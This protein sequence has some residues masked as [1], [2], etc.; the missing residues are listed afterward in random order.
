MG[1]ELI[2]DDKAVPEGVGWDNTFSETADVDK[3]QYEEDETW[4]KQWDPND[5]GKAGPIRM[6][7]FWLCAIPGLLLP[8]C[9]SLF[10]PAI[11]NVFAEF[12]VESAFIQTLTLSIYSLFS[13][14]FPLVWGPISDRYSRKWVLVVN[15][16]IYAVVSYLNSWNFTIWG[17]IVM[18]SLVAIPIASF[19][20]VVTG[21]LS[22]IFREKERA[23]WLGV[24]NLPGFAAVLFAPPIGGLLV[25]I[26][27]WRSTVIIQ[28]FM[29][30]G[31]MLI[32]M[33]ML[34]ETLN[35]KQAVSNS[36]NP[37]LPVKIMLQ[38]KIL[39][40]ALVQG[41]GFAAMYLS[42]AAIPLTFPMYYGSGYF[43]IGLSLVP[44]AL[45]CAVGA[46]LGGKTTNMIKARY[47]S[48]GTLI[49]SLIW[50]FICLPAFIGWGFTLGTTPVWVPVIFTTLVGGVRTATTPPILMY[51]IEQNPKSSSAVNGGLLAVQFIFGAIILTVFP[52]L[53]KEGIVSWGY[54]MVALSI[55]ELICF[56]PIIYVTYKTYK[57]NPPIK[58]EDSLLLNDDGTPNTNSVSN[59]H[60]Q[61]EQ[62][63]GYVSDGSEFIR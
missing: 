50:N 14:V 59:F 12:N 40:N 27:G 37:L 6:R 5:N 3:A 15:L 19:F 33:Y 22:D 8:L 58:D 57:E 25:Y 52:P 63:L 41:L 46:I 47:G 51:C 56:I 42:V 13:G 32:I 29:G 60:R 9:G 26:W 24:R 23:F 36:V 54:L 48:A 21:I 55:L 4:Y 34:P 28:A 35:K 17:V 38:P 2:T 45:G 53:A 49:S 10:L 39:P 11:P 44:F 62:S 16:F 20:V 18:R 30:I 43:V 31:G 61:R 1:R 7:I